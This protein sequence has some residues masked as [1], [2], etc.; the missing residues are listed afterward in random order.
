MNRRAPA[1][2]L[3]EILIG[4]ALLGILAYAVSSLFVTQSQFSSQTNRQEA[5]AELMQTNVI[6]LE[7]RP[8]SELPNFGQCRYRFYSDAGG[9]VSE[10]VAAAA[11][12]ACQEAVPEK[13]GMKI[14]LTTSP[15]DPTSATFKNPDGT[16]NPFLK[17]PTAVSTL[18]A[19]RIQGGVRT[20]GTTKTGS[21]S[22]TVFKQ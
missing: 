5:L 10:G 9:F 17:L 13:P 22:M 12:P 6:E 14:V 8:S 18:K 16:I 11:D 7:V 3:I 15:V 1:F 2:T 4:M 20:M 21:L 19:V